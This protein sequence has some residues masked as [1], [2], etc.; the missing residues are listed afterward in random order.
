MLTHFID[1]GAT[2]VTDDGIRKKLI[3]RLPDKK[4]E[5]E[6]MSFGAISRYTSPYLY[7]SNTETEQLTWHLLVSRN[8][9]KTML[10]GFAHS[11]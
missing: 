11:P 2:H 10:T 8:R 3:S 9:S 1:C 7:L 4:A 5:I 6:G